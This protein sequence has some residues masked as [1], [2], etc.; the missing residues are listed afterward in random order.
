MPRYGE[1]ALADLVPSLLAGCGV[2][3][4]A[5]VLGIDGP[6]KVCLL[7]VDGLGDRLLRAHAVADAPYLAG[8]LAGARTLTAGF[9][10][11]TATSLASIG[12]GLPPG[13]HGMLGYQVAIPGTGRLLNA[14][15]WDK[16]VDPYDWQ[17][18]PTAFARAEQAG[19]AVHQIGP[20][21]FRGSGLTEAALRGARYVAAETPGDV[22]AAALA[23]LADP[24]PGL[25][26]AYL[27][28]LD[29]TG[30]LRG[31]RS[32]A[33]R[34]QL[35]VVDRVVERL[36]TGLPAGSLLCI[37]GDHG[38]VDVDP[39]DRV[40]VDAVPDLAAGVTLLAG[41]PRARAVHARPG[42]A[43]DVLATWQQLLGDRAWV[44]PGE[45]AVAEGWYGPLDPRFRDRIGDVISAAHGP[46]A[47]VATRAEPHESRLIGVHGSLTA[48]EQLVPLLTV[49]RR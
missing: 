22:V 42:A 15:R 16:A 6:D 18:T 36:A 17:P 1:A 30:H 24:G 27:A 12:T 31:C 19:V 44:V 2:P 8:L 11:T 43:D 38:M 34:H 41:E 3:G 14:L 32:P 26:Y 35:A 13:Q 4:Y 49:D 46:L 39:V 10:S 21:A 37:T 5:D 40:D 48:D 9:P 47:V 29:H 20:R 28:E 25:I 23:A 33:W 7:L 45:Q